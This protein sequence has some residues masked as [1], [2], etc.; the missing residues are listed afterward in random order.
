MPD[1]S[2]AS[3]NNM[4]NYSLA[5]NSVARFTLFRGVTD[6]TNLA[7]FD[8]YETGYSFLICLQIPVFLDKLGNFSQNT[9]GY[10][11]L[12]QNYRHIIE[13]EFRGA[14]GLE[15]I[16]S[17]VS[18]ISNGITDINVITKVNEQ[19]GSTFTM[20]YFERSG[21]IITKVNELFLR[22][23]KDPKTQVKRYNGL[24]VEP[25]NLR[26]TYNSQSDFNGLGSNE[27]VSSHTRGNTVMQEAGYQYEIFH[28]LL[29]ITDNTCLNV[30]KAY[31]LA[32]CQPNTANTS[33][34]NVTRGEIQFQEMGVQFNGIP[35][36]GRI[37]T[38]KAVNFLKYINDH[39]CFDE[40]EYGYRALDESDYSARNLG[41]SYH[42]NIEMA[43]SGG[44]EIRSTT[45][46]DMLVQDYNSQ[47]NLFNNVGYQ[48]VQRNLNG[49]VTGDENANVRAGLSEYTAFRNASSTGGDGYSTAVGGGYATNTSYNY[50]SSQDSV[51][52][53]GGEG[54]GNQSTVN[55]STVTGG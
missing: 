1:N 10:A 30:E 15:D 35:L 43:G 5:P 54:R 20:N 4:F 38:H 24:L 33:I 29:I 11:M 18:P 53:S 31:L 13:W 51:T 17:D 16:T 44:D 52:G 27:D 36:P 28:F 26:N 8:L 32:C 50:D 7:Q 3:V 2:N 19:G 41:V 55:N 23:V 45:E 34:Y 6:Y 39:T 40:M 47:A 46:K 14:Q 12:I 9:G 21:S 42:K 37:V 22:G 49:I 48:G 25:F